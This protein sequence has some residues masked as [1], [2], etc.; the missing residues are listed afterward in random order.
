MEHL[1][2]T[3]DELISQGFDASQIV[4]LTAKGRDS[5]DIPAG[6]RV[7]GHLLQWRDQSSEDDIAIETVRRFK[8]LESTVVVL[9]EIDPMLDGP[10][11]LELA[12]IAVSRARGYVVVLAPAPDLAKLRRMIGR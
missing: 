1:S 7:G 9:T 8:G 2:T 10:A 3:V 12:Y 4:V 5:S 11:S 6:A